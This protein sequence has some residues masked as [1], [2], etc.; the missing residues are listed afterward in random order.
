MRSSDIADVLALINADRLPG[1]P[2]VTPHMLRDA[3]RGR[4]AVDSSW[5]AELNHIAVDVLVG[6]DDRPVGAISHARRS[7]DAAGLILW[8]HGREQPD[9]MA[10]LIHH[11][12]ERLSDAR[13]IHAFD[14]A[15]AL[16]IGLEALPVRHRPATAAA[17]R[18]CG[19][20]G[21]DLWR[22]MH[23][24]LPAPELPHITPVE[25]TSSEPGT[26]QLTVRDGDQVAAEA[27][28]GLPLS[29]IGW[30]QWISVAPAHRRNGL[31]RGLLGTAL[32]MLTGLGAREVILYVD[33]DDPDPRS[34]RNRAAANRLYDNA[35][36]REID[37]LHSFFRTQRAVT[38][39]ND[40]DDP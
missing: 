14:F 33:D 19:F 25:V 10:G 5:W 16:T 8:M 3:A 26:R 35:G 23:R 36:F 32:D 9:T 34:E 20:E 38:D 37:R 18:S 22:Y 15:S 11:A 2:E 4:S 13:T 31:G 40:M 17:L 24:R 39:V 28:I 30:L 21:R 27:T 6:S 7:R 29:G 12:L 1:Q